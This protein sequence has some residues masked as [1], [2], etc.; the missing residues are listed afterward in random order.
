MANYSTLISQITTAISTNRQNLITG[1]SLQA[2]LLQM[3]SE[4]GQAGYIFGGVVNPGDSPASSDSN[5]F[6]VAATAGTYTN[7][8]DAT[9]NGGELAI[10]TYSGGSWG[11]NSVTSAATPVVNDLT[12]GGATSALSAEMG[13]Q[14]GDN[15]SQL[16]QE[17][18]EFSLVST[19][20]YNKDDA[21]C[22][23][24]KFVQ[25]TNGELA[26]SGVQK[27]SGWIPV[28]PGKTY[29]SSYGGQ[30]AF[31]DANK[32]YISGVSAS[33]VAFTAP[34]NA[35]Y[36]RASF[37]MDS[38]ATNQLN[39][40]A[41]LLSYEPYYQIVNPERIDVN[42]I[43]KTMDNYVQTKGAVP[44][45]FTITMG[46]G[47]YN[48][49][50]ESPI[51]G[52]FVSSFISVT[53]GEVILWT[54]KTVPIAGFN[55]IWGYDSNQTGGKFL[56]ANTDE[57]KN[58]ERLVIPDGI[59]YIKVSFL[60]NQ[61]FAIERPIVDEYVV[62]KSGKN[63]FDKDGLLNGNYIS[64]NG[65]QGNDAATMAL[66]G[67]LSI[68]PSTSY[69]FSDA[70]D[71]APGNNSSL[72]QFL[73]GE[74]SVI[75][76]ISADTKDFTSPANAVYF[77]A[78]VL[79]S[80]EDIQLEEGNAR[81]NYEPFNKIGGY[82]SSISA[83]TRF[84]TFRNTG[85][86][87]NGGVLTLPKLHIVKNILLSGSIE[88][89]IDANGVEVGVGFVPGGATKDY[90]A[91]WLLITD[92]T[93]QLYWNRNT[94]DLPINPLLNH[95]LTLTSLTHFAIEVTVT[96]DAYTATFRLANDLGD[97]YTV[98]IM[99][100]V[101][102]G[103]GVGMP[104]VKSRCAS[105]VNV[106]LSFAPRDVTKKIWCFGDSYFSFLNNSRWPYYAKADGNI[107][108]FSNNQ[109]GCTPE[110][111]YYDLVNMLSLGHT[112]TYL[113]WCLGMNGDAVE[114][115]VDGQYVINTYQKTWID[116][117]LALCE[118]RDIIPVFGIV[119]TVPTCQKTGFG[120]YIK[121]LGVRYV[122]FAKAVGATS[123][124]VW[125]TGL[126]SSDGVHPSET[127]GKVLY[128]QI[129]ADFP[130]ISINE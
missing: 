79:Q 49:G 96:K 53:P 62:P 52:V 33:N 60:L 31:Y 57:F 73:D 55:S 14:I 117:V 6:Y 63:K 113:L 83:K 12:T 84:G 87:A 89:A 91:R 48:T 128:S 121:S 71:N 20:L 5:L 47:I 28:I 93:V 1:A 112:P 51:T 94:G 38:D 67:L 99:N 82:L 39:Q 43:E 97:V 18:N 109:G 108:W 123:A 122:D 70:Y 65:R 30:S 76:T 3:V 95:G 64:T 68:N 119:P 8:N 111:A 98:N 58:R 86:L 125:N 50:V 13:K 127:G 120:G 23:N 10:F 126:L 35:V 104:F 41:T 130:E 25:Y 61:Y 114:T 59:S 92:T 16:S 124:G 75:S 46:K 24:N 115:Q 15:I 80:A 21:D 106:S 110:S 107:N 22:V 81:T 103:W 17:V 36:L 85:T 56:V 100:Y 37:R 34:A 11:K 118:E 102:N 40:S 29:I 32:E 101:A 54:G 42:S 116:A 90:D 77:R 78:S 88:G 44:V 19:N 2:V 27:A 69:H 129:L 4:L 74:R 9:V 45:P 105:S 7:F 72:H 26:N 66:S